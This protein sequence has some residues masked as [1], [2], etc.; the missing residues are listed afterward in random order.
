MNN[1]S[2]L[3]LSAAATA[4][5]TGP[6]FGMYGRLHVEQA[7]A[8]AKAAAKADATPDA[9]HTAL[10]ESA[11]PANGLLTATEASIVLQ[12]SG[13]EKSALRKVWGQAKAKH[14][15]SVPKNSMNLAQFLL[16]CKLVV[17]AG[18]KFPSDTI[19]GDEPEEEGQVQ[20]R[21]TKWSK[22]SKLPKNIG[23]LLDAHTHA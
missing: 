10:F 3:D 9:G 2:L 14:E 23:N 13:L 5:A 18:G 17:K 16:A 21:N 11:N 4:T 8:A 7:L 6:E 1:A 12:E 20:R 15:P 19:K 22:D